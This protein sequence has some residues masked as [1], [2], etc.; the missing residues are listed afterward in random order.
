MPSSAASR[1]PAVEFLAACVNSPREIYK[2]LVNIARGVKD[3]SPRAAQA[4]I[5]REQAL[6]LDVREPSEY[7]A[8]HVPNSVLIPLG[9]V[10]ARAAELQQHRERPIVVICHGGKRSA[11]A[12]LRLRA[13]GFKNPMNIAGGI[14][15][16]KKAR[17]PVEI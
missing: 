16:W 7:E 11:T 9:Q 5:E 10:E 14:L 1:S 15:A 4:C 2:R 6:V 8:G 3:I 12:C 13:Q 17:L